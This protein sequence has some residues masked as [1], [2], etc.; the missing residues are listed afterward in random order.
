[1]ATAQGRNARA[2]VIASKHT[3]TEME[4]ELARL[5]TLPLAS[6]RAE[7]SKRFEIDASAIRSRAAL[8]RMLA[9]QT[10][11]DAFGDLDA[12]TKRRL[13]H[14]GGKLERDGTFE[15]AG[16]RELPPGTI[17]SREWKGVIHTATVADDGFQHLG[18]TYGSLSD[19]ARTI[20]GTRWSGPRFFGLEQKKSQP[21]KDK[22]VP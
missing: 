19:I 5:I 7:W 20:T 2:R 21:D 10:Q 15:P 6:L 3:A 4:T 16:R 22:I 12:E 9:W 18:K 17:L 11:A 14:I 8:T 1:M 13:I